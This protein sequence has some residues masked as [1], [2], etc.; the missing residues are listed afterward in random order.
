MYI[1]P[2][3][4]DLANSI[5]TE[6][7][8]LYGTISAEKLVSLLE[9]PDCTP[10]SFSQSSNNYG[11]F[12]FIGFELANIGVFHFYG[13]GENHARDC[14]QKDFVENDTSFANSL[15]DYK[16]SQ[17][18]RLAPNKETV[19][20]QKERIIAELKAA[21]AAAPAAEKPRSARGRAFSFLEKLT[22]SDGAE[23]FL[24]DFPET[25]NDF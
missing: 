10:Y 7:E 13:L 11:E 9:R 4:Q 21:I 8:Q 16:S 12:Y 23:S 25:E 19:A 17:S 3:C 24:N 15:Y 14:F 5:F 1:I 22:D 20:K 18:Y 2:E 6:R